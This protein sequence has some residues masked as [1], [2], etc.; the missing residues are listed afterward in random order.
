MGKMLRRL[1]FI[2]I[3]I[4]MV[5]GVLKQLGLLGSGECTADCDCSR[6]STGCECGHKTC[7]AH[8]PGL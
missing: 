4:G 8:V 7:L 3:A 1:T 2:A 6:G 5:L